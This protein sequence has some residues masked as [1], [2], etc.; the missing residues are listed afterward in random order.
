[1]AEPRRADPRADSRARGVARRPREI[2]R[3]VDGGRV[4]AA[5]G[6]QHQEPV[7]G[8]HFAVM[9]NFLTVTLAVATLY[10]SLSVNHAQDGAPLA[11]AVLDHVGLVVR[12]LDAAA[13]YYAE[14]FGAPV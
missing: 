14:V 7:T 11:G 13:P 4:A 3:A 12:D 9:R 8:L 1:A 6:G 2:P 5:R 10:T